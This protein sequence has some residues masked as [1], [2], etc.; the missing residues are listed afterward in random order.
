MGAVYGKM[1]AAIA[2]HQLLRNFPTSENPLP[3]AGTVQALWS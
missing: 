2:A 1:Q 3:T